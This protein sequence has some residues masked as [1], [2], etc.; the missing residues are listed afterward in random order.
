MDASELSPFSSIVAAMT[1]GFTMEEFPAGSPVANNANDFREPN[2]VRCP[3]LPSLSPAALAAAAID[4][5][6]T[7]TFRPSSLCTI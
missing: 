3:S 2:L 7:T 5:K 4:R 1:K 6:G